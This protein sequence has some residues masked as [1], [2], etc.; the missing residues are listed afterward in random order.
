MG[1]L[2]TGFETIKDAA[3]NEKLAAIVLLGGIF[4]M[5][6]APHWLNELIGPAAQGIME[7]LSGK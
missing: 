3:W 5:G 2:Q 7:Q 1:P 4:A 6:L